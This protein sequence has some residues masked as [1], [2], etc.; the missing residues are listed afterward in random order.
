[1]D[2]PPEAINE[3]VEKIQ[4]PAIEGLVDFSDQSSPG[5][6]KEAI[7]AVPIFIINNFAD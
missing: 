7:S 2:N 4:V 1:M 6:R 3:A 5:P